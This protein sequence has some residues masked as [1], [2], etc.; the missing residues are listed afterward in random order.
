[1]VTRMRLQPGA[2]QD[3]VPLH[4]QVSQTIGRGINSM[5]GFEGT[6]FRIVSFKIGSINFKSFDM[7]W[8]TKFDNHPVVSWSA[9]SL[10]FPTV[11]HVYR[12]PRHY[13][14]MAMTKKH[15]ATGEHQPTIFNRG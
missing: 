3:T 13:Q 4:R 2:G 1:I 11:T 9:T 7:S 12:A 5:R 14:I 6:A 15:V 8:S 10:R